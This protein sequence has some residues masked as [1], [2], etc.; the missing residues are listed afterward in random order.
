[1]SGP[2][3]AGPAPT[4]ERWRLGP[5][6]VDARVVALAGEGALVPAGCACCGDVAAESRLER[7]ARGDKSVIVPYCGT[8]HRHASAFRTRV[9]AAT[10]ASC[11]LAVT[12]AAG[13]PL[14]FE[15]LPG[16]LFITIVL[17][18]ALVPPAVAWL[19]PRGVEAAHT[20]SGRAAWW[21]RDGRLACTHPRWAA[22]LAVANGTDPER[23]LLRE[24]AVSPWMLSGAIVALAAAPFFQWLYHPLVRVLD[25]GPD[26]VELSVDGRP[27]AVID[28]TSAESPQAGVEL[29]LPSG[30][31]HL[32]VRD[33]ID[34]RVVASADVTIEAGAKHLYAPASD[35]Y[36]FWLETNGYGRAGAPGPGIRPLQGSTRFWALP[37]DVDSW[38]APNPAPAV[39]DRRSSGGVLTALRQAPCAEAPVEA[40]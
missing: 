8:C 32:D 23:S 39:A 16:A 12:L 28:P 4:R 2:A 37:L 15:W 31:R 1:M 27:V 24:P 3:S 22:E 36:C 13:L 6:I 10:L 17:V 5:P 9:L 25:L 20:A 18:G 7:S 26:R 19:W 21:L 29:H 33:V 34:G 14:L 38:F 11:L 40:R 35:E 30:R